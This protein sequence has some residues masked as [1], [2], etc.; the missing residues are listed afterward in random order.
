MNYEAIR[1]V[2]AASHLLDLSLSKFS[3]AATRP[4]VG[5]DPTRIHQKIAFR[6]ARYPAEV[7][8]VLSVIEAKFEATD[9]Q[10]QVLADVEGTWVAVYGLADQTL[11]DD[12][13]D[14]FAEVNGIYHAWPY[15]REVVA[16]CAARLGLAGI[17]LPIWRLP[18]EFPLKGEFHEMSFTPAHLVD[19]P[20][21]AEAKLP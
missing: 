10:H 19:P 21:S 11:P 16:S 14:S 5:I 13:I 18:D 3:A 12:A 17:V 8:L 15:I 7:G 6:A 20:E 4:L 1:P 9:D 2:A